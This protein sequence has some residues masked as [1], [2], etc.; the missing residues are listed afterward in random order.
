MVWRPVAGDTAYLTPRTIGAPSAAWKEPRC[1]VVR[2]TTP[3]VTVRLADGTEL[4]THQDNVVSRRPDRRDRR[5]TTPAPR[6]RP[7]LAD[8]EEVPL[9]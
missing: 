8:C 3:E 6:P 7:A 1:T 5:R 9:W 2:V 4:T